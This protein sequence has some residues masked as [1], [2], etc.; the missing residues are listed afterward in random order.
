MSCKCTVLSGD[1]Y[2][3]F[4][5]QV[6]KSYEL[7]A[8]DDKAMKEFLQK[9]GELLEGCPFSDAG[10]YFIDLNKKTTERKHHEFRCR[11]LEGKNKES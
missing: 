2:H 8:K 9:A 7:K 11:R 1:D 5:N 3:F 6:N 4:Y 10:L